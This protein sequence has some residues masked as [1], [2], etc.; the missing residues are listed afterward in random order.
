MKGLY[1]FIFTLFSTLLIYSSISLAV[2][3]T[4]LITAVIQKNLTPDQMLNRLIQGNKRFINHQRLPTDLIK[5]AQ[6]TVKGQYPGAIVL[7]CIDSRIAPEIVFDQNVGNI[8]VTRVAANVLNSDVLGGME[9]ATQVAGA[10]LI[11][12]MGHD[13]CG[14]VR[15]ACEDVKLGHLTQLLAKIQPSIAQATKTVGKKDCN[16]EK[17]IDTAAA[18]NVRN[19]VKMIP[20]ESPVIRKLVKAGKVKIVGAMYDLETGEVAF[21]KH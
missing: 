3:E 10:K 2:T 11:V 5:K 4:P 9:F 6:L 15:G 19:V 8:F 14:A 1:L 20:K 13:A 17:F 16:S 7:S 18:D 12:V 21:F